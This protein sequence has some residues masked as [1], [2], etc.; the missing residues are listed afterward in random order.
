MNSLHLLGFGPRTAS[1]IRD[2]NKELYG[3]VSQ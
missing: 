3:N 2:L 1:A